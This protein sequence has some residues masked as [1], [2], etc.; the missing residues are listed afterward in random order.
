MKLAAKTRFFE[1]QRTEKGSCKTHTQTRKGPSPPRLS[2]KGRPWLKGPPR[3]RTT[4]PE[5]AALAVGTHSQLRNRVKGLQRSRDSTQWP[6]ESCRGWETQGLHRQQQWRLTQSTWTRWVSRTRSYLH[7]GSITWTSWDALD[8][9]PP[10]FPSR[11]LLGWVQPVFLQHTLEFETVVCASRYLMGGPATPTNT[12][13]STTEL[14]G[15]W[16]H[17]LVHTARSTGASD[18]SHPTHTYIYMLWPISR[19]CMSLKIW[20]YLQ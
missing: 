17:C 10:L 9:P 1:T 15:M 6:G 18:L 2:T 19:V 12:T 20:N 16:P 7:D 13:A 3:S 8:A 4:A 5:P 11:T 14:R